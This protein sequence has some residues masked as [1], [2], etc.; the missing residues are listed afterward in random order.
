MNMKRITTHWEYGLNAAMERASVLK[1]PVDM[2][3]KAW[4]IASYRVMSPIQ[5]STA[6]MAVNAA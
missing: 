1:P 2:V 6:S 3:V 5:S 4:A